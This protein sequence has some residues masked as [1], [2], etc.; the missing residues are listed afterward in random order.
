VNDERISKLLRDAELP[1]EHEARERSWRVVHAALEEP[2]PPPD[3]RRR[4]TRPLLALGVGT[5]ALVLV[6]SPAGAKVVSAIRSATGIGEGSA[7]P[8]LTALPASGSLVVDSADGPWVVHDDGSKRLLGAYSQ[9]TFSPHGLYLAV[10]RGHELAAVTPTGDVRWTIDRTKPVH[11]AQWSP[12]GI[13]VA[14]LSGRT[15]RVA[16]GDASSDVLVDRSVAPVA[17]AWRPLRHPTDATTTYAPGTNVLAFVDSD[18]RIV[19]IDADTGETL[20]RSAPQPSPFELRWSS[21]GRELLAVTRHGLYTYRG[22][23]SQPVWAALAPNQ[24]MSDAAF[25]P[26]SNRVVATVVTHSGGRTRSQVRVGRP[27]VENFLHRTLYSGLGR[28]AEVQPAPDGN[29][30]L[31]AWPQADQWLFV[32]PR[33]AKVQAVGHISRQFDP[34]ATPPVSF[35]RI[36]GWCCAP[37]GS[38]PK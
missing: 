33:D 22:F 35:P 25:L 36:E 15:L 6:L 20:M 29:W 32:R 12:S 1:G 34:G 28:L 14:F 10:S 13:R 2:A 9:A 27:D 26:E 19:V 16:A 11:D 3:K 24:S 7:K 4:L 18:H 23:G 8:A 31:V 30:V 21:D 17:P 5:L 37:S 38:L